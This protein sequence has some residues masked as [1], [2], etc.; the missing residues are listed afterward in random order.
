MSIDNYKR[1]IEKKLL[2][3]VEEK[4][5]KHKIHYSINTD[6]I[7]KESQFDGFYAVCTNLEDNVSSIIVNTH[8][9]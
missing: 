6:L 8:E 2:T 1:F 9:F 7:S 5:V 4:A 3:E